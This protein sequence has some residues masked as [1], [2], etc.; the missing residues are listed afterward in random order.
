MSPSLPLSLSGLLILYLCIP[1]FSGTDVT[2]PQQVPASVQKLLT[3]RAA[4]RAQEDWSAS[5]LLHAPV[6]ANLCNHDGVL[7]FV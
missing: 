4:A 6:G 5:D 7:L 2:H 3:Q 1:W